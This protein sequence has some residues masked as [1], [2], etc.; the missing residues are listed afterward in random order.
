MNVN[1]NIVGCVLLR[2]ALYGIIVTYLFIRPGFNVSLLYV[3]SC[4]VF[5]LSASA[6]RNRIMQFIE[7]NYTT[8]GNIITLPKWYSYIS[9]A[10]DFVT[11]LFVLYRSWPPLIYVLLVFV[12]LAIT[13]QLLVRNNDKK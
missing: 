9:Y 3:A 8:L 7:A 10:M 1:R 12:H 6:W 11:A 4:V 5:Y 2:E 13:V